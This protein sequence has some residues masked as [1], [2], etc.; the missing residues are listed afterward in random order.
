MDRAISHPRYNSFTADND[1]AILHLP[2]EA[3]TLISTSASVCLPPL[4]EPPPINHRCVIVGWGTTHRFAK[5]GSTLLREAKVFNF[6]L[7]IDELR[8]NNYII[9]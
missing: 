4:S 2:H 7:E 8:L 1:I 9:L 3:S 5:R 6:I